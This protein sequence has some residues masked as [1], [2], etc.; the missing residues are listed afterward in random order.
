MKVKETGNFKR[1]RLGDKKL[2]KLST[3]HLDYNKTEEDDN[4]WFGQGKNER[5]DIQYHGYDRNLT[6]PER[7]KR[8]DKIKN[9]FDGTFKNATVNNILYRVVN[10]D[11]DKYISKGK[12]GDIIKVPFYQS[13]SLSKDYVLSAF[14]GSATL[15]YKIKAKK[16]SKLLVSN[17]L[18]AEVVIPTQSK[19]KITD[20]YFDGKLEIVELELLK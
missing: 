14:S 17:E 8:I 12:I 11:N 19:F 1:I 3:S 13:T 2:I 20:K 4:L 10:R 6:S 9:K 16:R 18:E 7:R 15:L 5:T